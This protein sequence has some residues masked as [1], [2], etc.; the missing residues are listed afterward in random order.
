MTNTKTDRIFLAILGVLTAL[1]SVAFIAF[2][3]YW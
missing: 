1:N 3:A 2:K